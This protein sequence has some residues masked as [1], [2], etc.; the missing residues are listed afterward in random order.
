M[1]KKAAISLATIYSKVLEG[2][3]NTQNAWLLGLG[4][5]LDLSYLV[6]AGSL[7]F[8]LACFMVLR[9]CINLMCLLSMLQYSQ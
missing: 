7:A 2:K 8:N 6:L 4:V 3:G 9:N 5:I 1:K